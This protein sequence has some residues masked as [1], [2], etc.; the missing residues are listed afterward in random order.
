MIGAESVLEIGQGIAQ[1]VRPVVDDRLEDGQDQRVIVPTQLGDQIGPR[2]HLLARGRL[3]VDV[4]LP[5]FGELRAGLLHH[6]TGLEIGHVGVVQGLAVFLGRLLDRLV[7]GQIPLLDAAGHRDDAS[8]V[9][10]VVRPRHA[11]LASDEL[12]IEAGP[13]EDLGGQVLLLGVQPDGIDVVHQHVQ[14]VLDRHAFQHAALDLAELVGISGDGRVVLLGRPLLDSGFLEL[15]DREVPAV[16]LDQPH[17]PVGP[18]GHHE[19]V[20]QAE[21]VHV[22]GEGVQLVFRVRD[23]LTGIP[24]LVDLDLAELHEL[25]GLVRVLR[26]GGLDALTVDDGGVGGHVDEVGG[27]GGGVDG[28]RKF[29]SFLLDC[30]QQRGRPD[31][32][33]RS[34]T[35]NPLGASRNTATC[36]C[37][38]VAGRWQSLIPAEP[39]AALRSRYFFEG[40]NATG[41][42][43]LLLPPVCTRSIHRRTMVAPQRRTLY[44]CS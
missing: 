26:V 29:S 17:G 44:Q 33:N 11:D 34:V 28:H 32:T 22:P 41:V 23:L 4:L 6:P 20:D 42:S 37:N 14:L 43:P 19:G 8:Q 21:L 3:Q 31:R 25:D 15:E 39:T 27:G 2:D 30:D 9:V 5:R 38:P 1:I 16:A 24:R 13:R 18:L 36:L 35:G 7:V 10:G 40:A 12:V